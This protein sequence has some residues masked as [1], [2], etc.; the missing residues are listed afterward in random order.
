MAEDTFHNLG[1]MTPQQF[2][3]V[4]WRQVHDALC[5]VPRMFQIFACKQVTNIAGVC[6]NQAKYMRDQDKI[7]PSCGQ[8]EETCQHVLC[9]EE[10]GRVK[11]LNCTIDLLDSWLPKVGTHKTLRQCLVTCAKRRG[12]SSM[13]N[14]VGGKGTRWLGL[15]RSMDSIGWRR[16]M[17]GM[18]SSEILKIQGVFVD[19]GNCSLS[20]DNWAQGL[21][22]KLLEVTHGQR[23]YRNI[24]VHDTVSGLK[25]VERKEELQR[26]IEHQILLGG[27]G[28]DRQDIYLLEINVGDLEISSG[29]DQYYW[30]LSI[31]A[32]RV[33]RRL[34]EMQLNSVTRERV[35]R[36]RAYS[37]SHL[38]SS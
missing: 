12:G 32:A 1:L 21:V 33:D 34:K 29:E 30:L 27:T 11:A 16:Y 8:E 28:L 3:E 17:E 10:E 9:C 36:R 18:V 14:I 6:V 22:T 5:E 25:A 31:R 15:A 13:E 19:L 26:E 4:A 38:T 23:L 24:Q 35:R 7:C 20:L 37:S 2:Q